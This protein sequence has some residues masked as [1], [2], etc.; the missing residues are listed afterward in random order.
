MLIL[1]GVNI[2]LLYIKAA[3]VQGKI[4]SGLKR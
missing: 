3:L 4:L 2:V 1:I